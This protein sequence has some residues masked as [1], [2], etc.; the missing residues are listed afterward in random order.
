M[1]EI[2]SYQPS[3]KE[4]TANI[5]SLPNP[6]L[7]QVTVDVAQYIIKTAPQFDTDEFTAES[8]VNYYFAGSFAANLLS[9]TN[10]F[11]EARVICYHAPDGENKQEQLIFQPEEKMMSAEARE[12]FKGF[13]RKLG[14]IDA[15]VISNNPYAVAKSVSHQEGLV[16]AQKIIQHVPQSTALFKGWN[17][18]TMV[19]PYDLVGTEHAERTTNNYIIATIVN[20]ETS[21]EILLAHP[22]DMIA[23]KLIELLLMGTPT[24][25]SIE[26][27][28]KIEKD[29]VILY[30]GALAMGVNPESLLSNFTTIT[31]NMGHTSEKNPKVMMKKLHHLLESQMENK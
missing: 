23:Y 28:H 1:N 12:T 25:A 6:D 16:S 29:I 15:A 4:A 3:N 27:F 20:K 30:N 22:S 2:R 19:Y 26:Y 7:S 9:R 13:T 21:S 5:E 14:D 18:K 10:S 24:E 17:E 8:Q 11:K 31:T